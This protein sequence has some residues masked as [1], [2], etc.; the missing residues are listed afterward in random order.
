MKTVRG[1]R[2][3]GYEVARKLAQHNWQ[4]I[5]TARSKARGTAAAAKLKNTSFLELDITDDSSVALA[6]SS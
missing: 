3:L 2:G 1:D 6:H 5:L 4:V